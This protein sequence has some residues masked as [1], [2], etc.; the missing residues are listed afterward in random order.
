MEQGDARIFGAA[1]RVCN[2]KLYNRFEPL[3]KYGAVGLHFEDAYLATIGETLERYCAGFYDEAAFYR[4]TYK[5]FKSHAVP[6]ERFALFSDEQYHIPNFPF[7]RFTEDL[8][9]DWVKAYSLTHDR[10]VCVPAALVFIPYLFTSHAERIAYQTTNGLACHG[11][12]AQAVLT[13]LCEVIERDA[14][15][16]TWLNALP[17]PLI[18][19][20]GETS[21]GSFLKAYKDVFFLEDLNYKAFDITLDIPI[22]SSMVLHIGQSSCGS[23]MTMGCSTRSSMQQSL[24]KSFLEACHGRQYARFLLRDTPVWRPGEDFS[25]VTNFDRHFLLYN[26]RPELRSFIPYL[27]ADAAKGYP[28]RS[29]SNDDDF[30][31]GVCPTNQFFGNFFAESGVFSI[32]ESVKMALLGQTPSK[33]ESIRSSEVYRRDA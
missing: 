7:S 27:N 13:A 25:D 16:I 33:V 20:N 2:T 23:L 3:K 6:P 12:Y 1:A 21:E 22:P 32:T 9:V 4:G 11:T 8:V 17:V 14:F 30:P 26:R 29:V 24:L 5:D 15:A 19:V 28:V 31:L 10:E 18:E